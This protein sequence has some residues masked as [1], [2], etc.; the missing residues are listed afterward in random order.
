MNILIIGGTGGIGSALINLLINQNT[1]NTIHSTYHITQPELMHPQ[2]TW[3]QVDV[4]KDSDVAE[5]SETVNQLDIVINAVG[6]LHSGD[7]M[8]EKTITQFDSDFFNQ[9][10]STN[11]LPTLLIAK[12]LS[13]K[14]KSK[15]LNYFVTVSAKIG[16]IEDN[17]LGGWISYRSS[18]AALNM[19][20]KTI[21]IEWKNK[22]FNTCVFAFH[23]GTTDTNLSKPFQRNVPEGNLQTPEKVAAAL[24]NLLQRLSLKDNGKF[25]SYDG[26]EIPW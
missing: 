26:T 3:Y 25:F 11:V 22:K 24:I 19:A 1:E 13:P 10:I 5:L 23:P 14:L 21:S 9:N 20:L 6:M 2:L 12:H 8:P 16:S 18:K 15:T 17:N 7:M 4:S